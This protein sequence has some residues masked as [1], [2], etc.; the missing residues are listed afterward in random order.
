MAN[1][2]HLSPKIIGLVIGIIAAVLILSASYIILSKPSS[3]TLLSNSSTTTINSA[4]SVIKIKSSKEN[5]TQTLE[6]NDQINHIA[7]TSNP[8]NSQDQNYWSSQDRVY[9]KLKDKWYYLDISNKQAYKMFFGTMFSSSKKLFTSHNFDKFDRAA[10]DKLKVKLDG[11]SGYH[12]SYQG[13]DADIIKGILESS[14]VTNSQATPLAN[15]IEKVVLNIKTDR[16]QNLRD[17]EYKLI[18][19]QD[20]GSISFHLSNINEV[21]KLTIPKNITSQ[22]KET[23]LENLQK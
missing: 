6:F 9:T 17:L 1:R 18:Y 3:S 16:H 22:A 2:Q 11:L 21:N 23:S 10:L 14:Q 15:Q 8:A 13:S 4:R 7:L 20:M 12:I 19:K 5:V